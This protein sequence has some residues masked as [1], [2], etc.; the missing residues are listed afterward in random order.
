MRRGT[1]PTLI[2]KVR[3]VEVSD[4]TSIF[5]TLKQGSKE[6]T[7]R[8]TDITINTDDNALEVPLTQTETLDFDDGYVN[9]QLRAMVGTKAIASDIK[10]VPMEHIL[11]EGLIE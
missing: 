4:L 2:I 10:T 6:L 3:G 11:K 9:I 1:S 8:E 7:A 5:L